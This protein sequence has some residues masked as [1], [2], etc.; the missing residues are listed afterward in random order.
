ETIVT[1]ETAAG[2]VKVTATCRDGRCEKVKLTM[3][4]S[5]VHELDVAIDTPHW[6]RIKADICYGGMFYALV[7]V[8]QIG[9]TIE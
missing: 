8:G 3:V 2:L 6:G 1:L 7:D 4:P 5:L 9:L